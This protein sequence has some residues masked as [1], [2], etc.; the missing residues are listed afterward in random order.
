MSGS[1]E[2]WAHRR[3]CRDWVALPRQVLHI[4][5]FHWTWPKLRAHE[6]VEAASALTILSA[7]PPRTTHRRSPRRIFA[8]LAGQLDGAV[9][10]GDFIPPPSIAPSCPRAQGA[11]ADES[12]G[13]C[14]SEQLGNIIDTHSAG[15][16][17]VWEVW[18]RNAKRGLLESRGID[19]TPVVAHRGGRCGM[20]PRPLHA[21]KTGG[22]GMGTNQAYRKLQLNVARQDR[23]Q[24]LQRAGG[25]LDEQGALYTT[26]EGETEPER[27]PMVDRGP[28]TTTTCME[29]LAQRATQEVGGEG[30]FT[31]GRNAERKRTTTQTCE[32]KLGRTTIL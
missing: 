15:P 18:A 27:R 2:A 21:P 25:C 19:D 7:G 28:E 1:Q 13:S 24:L 16:T 11:D 20:I 12:H 32:W 31:N 5:T 6:D 26:F 8:K 17:G 23:H 3:D 4:T 29:S 30:G 22:L 9:A 10:E 14:R